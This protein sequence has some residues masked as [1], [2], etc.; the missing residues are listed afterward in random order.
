MAPALPSI[1]DG[2]VVLAA[3]L[4]LLVGGAW[5]GA[6]AQD[7][8]APTVSITN[9]SDGAVVASQDSVAGTSSDNQQVDSVAV[10][11]QRRRDGNYWDGS[12]WVGT[13]TSVAGSP[14][15]GAFDSGN[16]DWGYDVS[17]ITGE[18]TY[19][20]TATAVDTASNAD[21]TSVTTYTKFAPVH[22]PGRET[23]ASAV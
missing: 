14:D 12:D 19:D 23:V 3:V 21:T 11:I 13:D 6:R 1:G 7:T 9:P 10:T 16:E 22:E 5:T 20:V 18:D 4:L 15:D 2:R 17:S 8:T